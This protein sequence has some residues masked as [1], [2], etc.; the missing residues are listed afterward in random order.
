MEN[1]LDNRIREVKRAKGDESFSL[2]KMGSPKDV[3]VEGQNDKTA[4]AVKSKPRFDPD[5][6]QDVPIALEHVPE[7][8]RPKVQLVMDNDKVSR[9]IVTC[10]C[11]ECVELECNY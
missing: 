2:P 10:S 8:K 7:G 6:V 11:G 5:A 9:I 1:F 4:S 3:E